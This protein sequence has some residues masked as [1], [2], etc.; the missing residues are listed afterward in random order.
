[1]VIY[2][3]LYNDMTLQ[4]EPHL[5]TMHWEMCNNKNKAK[6]LKA[7]TQF[8]NV[9]DDMRY[10]AAASIHIIIVTTKYPNL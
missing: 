4:S 1:M 6:K 3:H 2:K 10:S 9:I 5:L 7:G 8:G